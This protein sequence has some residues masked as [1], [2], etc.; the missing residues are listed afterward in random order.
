MLPLNAFFFIFNLTKLSGKVVY[1]LLSFFD[2]LAILVHFSL[3]FQ[4]VL[5]EFFPLFC[6]SVKLILN[7]IPL[8]IKNQNA[9]VFLCKL[10]QKLLISLPQVLELSSTFA[11]T[12]D[13]LVNPFL[14]IFYLLLKLTLPLL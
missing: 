14:K 6:F 5:S 4:L 10:P 2:A 8:L 3:F 9:L 11:G 1:Y 13:L 12:L 7:F